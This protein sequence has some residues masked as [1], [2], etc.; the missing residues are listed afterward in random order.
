MSRKEVNLLIEEGEG[1]AIEFKEKYSSKIDQDIVA[2]SNSRG[3][4][5]IIGVRDDKKIIGEKLTSG[6]KAQILTLARNCQPSIEVCVSQ[7]DNI[8]AI[9]VPEGKRKPYSCSSGFF[10]RLDAVTQKMSNEEI[11]AMFAEND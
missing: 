7:A 8:I 2:F 9:E 4:T 11:R 10:I 5:I 3:G 1:L 6:L